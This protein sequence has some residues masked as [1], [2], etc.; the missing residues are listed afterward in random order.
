MSKFKPK[1]IDVDINSTSLSSSDSLGGHYSPSSSFNRGNCTEWK[2]HPQ[3]YLVQDAAGNG[4]KP[5]HQELPFA[6]GISHSS[7][8]PGLS[9]KTLICSVLWEHFISFHFYCGD[10]SFSQKSWATMMFQ[11]ISQFCCLH[12]AP[13][14]AG[15]VSRH[16]QFSTHPS[17][18]KHSGGKFT[19]FK[20]TEALRNNDVCLL[21]VV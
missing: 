20:V 14:A 12:W 15:E 21:E 1:M 17:L 4:C 19:F 10:S 9:G 5:I 16:I 6:L 7:S 18:I 3:E 11:I 13:T 2:H 8:F